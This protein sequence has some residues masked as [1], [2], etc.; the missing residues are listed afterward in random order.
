MAFLIPEYARLIASL[1]PKEKAT[2]KVLVALYK[3]S[4]RNFDRLTALPQVRTLFNTMF[5]DIDFDLAMVGVALI[6]AG[7]LPLNVVLPT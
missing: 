4:P 6:A 2:L 7:T 5:P 3:K 1:G